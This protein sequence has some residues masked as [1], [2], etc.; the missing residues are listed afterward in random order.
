MSFLNNKFKNYIS[1]ILISALI[2]LSGCGLTV[3]KVDNTSDTTT[4]P[5]LTTAEATSKKQAPTTSVNTSH[6]VGI[7]Q[8]SSSATQSNTTLKNNT[9][10]PKNETP[11]FTTL[12][13][14]TSTHIK[15]VTCTIE[16]E[17]KTILNN[18]DKLRSEK[19]SFLPSN[20]IILKATTVT[21]KEGATVFDVLEKV[22]SENACAQGCSYC[23]N[24]GIQTDHVYTPA[25]DSEYIRGIHQLYEKD[26]GTQ[27]GWM[28]SVN[29]VYPNYGVNKYPVKNGDTIRFRYTCDLG[30]DIGG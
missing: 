22:C 13:S 11:T 5:A 16:I 21:V 9:T 27:S 19:K 6:T 26:C 4:V 1:L 8:K 7:T 24:D 29:G 30:S 14:V 20:G 12:N 2:L 28:Y 23:K 18:L 15:T 25:Y 10:K 3:T 17:C